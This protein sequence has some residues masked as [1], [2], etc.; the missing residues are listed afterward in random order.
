MSRVT[1]RHQKGVGPP[2]KML[3]AKKIKKKAGCPLKFAFQRDN[4]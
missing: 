3:D 4:K 1:E 2:Y